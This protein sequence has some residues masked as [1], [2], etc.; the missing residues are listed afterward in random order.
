MCVRKKFPRILKYK[1]VQVILKTVQM[2][3]EAYSQFQFKQLVL[4]L[5]RTLFRP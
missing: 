4:F 1:L 5:Q 3:Q 2:Y